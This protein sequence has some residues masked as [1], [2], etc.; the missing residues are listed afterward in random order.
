MGLY[1]LELCVGDGGESRPEQSLIAVD[2]SVLTS[3]LQDLSNIPVHFL[4]GDLFL[5]HFVM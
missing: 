2:D 4:N 1:L 5:G 3:W